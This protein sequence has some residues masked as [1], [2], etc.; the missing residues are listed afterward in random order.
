MSKEI[1]IRKKDGR[2]V[3]G[4]ERSVYAVRGCIVVMRWIVVGE[5]HVIVWLENVEVLNSKNFVVGCCL[6]LTDPQ[7]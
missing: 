4:A 2:S 6:L 1:T 5:M 7:K 3:Q